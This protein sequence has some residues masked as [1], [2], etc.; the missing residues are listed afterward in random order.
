MVM[1]FV[2]YYHYDDD[3][4]YTAQYVITVNKALSSSLYLILIFIM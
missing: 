3:P 1:A 4:F 2:E